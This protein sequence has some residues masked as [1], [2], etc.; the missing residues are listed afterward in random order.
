MSL[1]TG[2]QTQT[3]THLDLRRSPYELLLAAFCVVIVISNVAATKAVSIG[4]GELSLGPIQIWP[5]ILDGGA[6]LFPL[7]YVLGDVLAEVYGFAA[8]RRAIIAGLVASAL[9][10][11]TFW[12][13]AALPT[14]AGNE[15]RAEAFTMTLGPVPQIV[16]ASLV[17]FAAGQLLNAFV[18]SR[19][20]QRANSGLFTRLMASSLVGQI[21]DTFLFCAIAA[22]AIGIVGF[23][24]FLNYFVVGVLFKLTVEFCFL[25]VTFWVIA[26]VQSRESRPAK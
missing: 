19:M 2:R 23:G 17:A 24:S 25:P 16:L 11:L 7:A 10:A 22:S 26:Q 14:M 8:S 12:V 9:A 20:K 15:A 5:L 21:V 3:A 18:V 1:E 6:V 13:V 4:S